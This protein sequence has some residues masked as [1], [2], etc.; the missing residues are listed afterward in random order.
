M[1]SGVV[2]AVY[3]WRFLDCDI[4]VYLLLRWTGIQLCVSNY[5]EHIDHYSSA[6][7]FQLKAFNWA[8]NEIELKQ[9]KYQIHLNH[10]QYSRILYRTVLYS[11]VQ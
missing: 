6:E 8:K 3:L 7:R 2:V 9:K 4:L 11:T 1:S 5:I 10:V